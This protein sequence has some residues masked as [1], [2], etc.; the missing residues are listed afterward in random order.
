MMNK[1]ADVAKLLGQ[2]LD[3]EFIVKAENERG[4]CK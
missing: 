1:M 4:S 3:E 2:E